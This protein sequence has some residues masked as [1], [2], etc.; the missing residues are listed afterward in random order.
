MKVTT[1]NLILLFIGILVVLLPMILNGNAE[2]GGADG[3]AEVVINKVSPDYKPWFEPFW[4]PPSSEIESMLFA[5]QASIGTGIIAYI[6][7]YLKG[8]KN[9][10][11]NR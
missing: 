4:E 3:M 11:Y 9:S 7:G 1:K 8:K 6:M 5:I 2:F 10:A